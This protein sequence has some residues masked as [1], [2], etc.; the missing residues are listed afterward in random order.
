MGMNTK[1]RIQWRL[2]NVSA[3]TD[4]SKYA[5]SVDPFLGDVVMDLCRRAGLTPDMVDVSELYDDVVPGYKIASDNGVD[6]QLGPL[7][8]AFFF[9]PTE[10]DRKLHFYK[11]GRDVVAMV[12]YNDLVDDG[13]VAMKQTRVQEDKLPSVVH[14]THLDPAGAYAKNKQTYRRKSNLVKAKAEEKIEFDMVL[15]ADQAADVALKTLKM[16]WHELMSYAWALPIGFTALVPADV[17]DFAAK[18]GSIQRIRITSR[19]EDGGILKF[20]GKQDAGPLTYGS[21]ASGNPLPYPQSTT[22]GLIGETR[23]ELLNIPVLRDQ[24]DELGIYVA[25]AGNSSAWYG[26]QILLS[27]DG[28]VNYFEAFRG[29][30]PAT[31]GETETALEAEVSAEYQDNQTFDVAMNF[32]LEST[33]PETLLSNYNRM[34]VGDEILQFQT[35]TPL[36]DNRFRLSGLVR[37]RYNTQPEVWPVGTRVVLLDSS[38]VFLQAQRWMLGLELLFK[39]VSFGLTEDESVPTAYTFEQAMSQWEWAPTHVTAVR[40]GADAV[41]VDWIPRPRLGVETGPYNSKYFTGVKLTW[42]DGFTATV[43]KDVTTY[44]RASTPAGATVTLCG[45]NSITGDGESTEAIP[46]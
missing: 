37:A 42:S 29:S 20:E 35:A 10:F 8:Q 40:D 44:T 13:E 17:I 2:T 24:D 31:M 15:T 43:G 46:T 38:V 30:L 22:P 28:G 12:T 9:D 16:D 3:P 7:K 5:V 14:V 25:I 18:D 32:P 4:D 27:T 39:P 45:I 26:A 19:N 41:T 23:L 21:H 33:T 36:G 11:R 34:V 1:L 6:T